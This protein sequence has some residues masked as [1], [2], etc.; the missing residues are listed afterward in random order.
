MDFFKKNIDRGNGQED[1]SPDK[2]VKIQRVPAILFEDKGR[3]FV[4][5]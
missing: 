5:K 3:V 1:V 2:R 4:S